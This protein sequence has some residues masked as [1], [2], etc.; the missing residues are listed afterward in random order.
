MYAMYFVYLL[1][2]EGGRIYTGITTNV[3]RRFSEHVAGKGGHFT[4]SMKPKKVLYTE[5][6]PSRSAAL[7]REAQIKS[8]A[9]DKKVRLIREAI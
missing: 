6:W 8:W 2:C 4:R 1:E 7:K 9:R 5:Q 3:E